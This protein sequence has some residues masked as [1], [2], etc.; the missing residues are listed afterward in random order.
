MG[1]WLRGKQG[2]D[3]T[4]ALGTE[5]GEAGASVSECWGGRG[6]H[7]KTSKA[8]LTPNQVHYMLGFCFFVFLFFLNKVGIFK[9]ID[10]S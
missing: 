3:P 9:S 7:S 1:H 6:S 2:A 10:I 4:E 5:V 8:I